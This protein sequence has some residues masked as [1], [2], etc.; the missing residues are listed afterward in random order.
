MISAVEKNQNGDQE[1]HRTG[2]KVIVFKR[3]V[4]VWLIEKRH[5]SK[6]LKEKELAMGISGGR[7]FQ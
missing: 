6:D 5:L 2:G 3:G 7:A 4:R 1:C